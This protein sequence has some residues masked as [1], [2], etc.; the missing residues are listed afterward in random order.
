MSDL[1]PICSSS[2]SSSTDDKHIILSEAAH[3]LTLINDEP[4]NNQQVT[5]M[6]AKD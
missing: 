4:L 2:S 6:N 1:S 3:W 5:I